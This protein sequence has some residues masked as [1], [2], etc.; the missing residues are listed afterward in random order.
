MTTLAA[1]RWMVETLRGD[2][3]LTALL[4]SNTS[5]YVGKAPQGAARPY[6]L[7][8]L[9]VPRPDVVVVGAM[10]VMTDLGYLVRAIAEARTFSVP[11]AIAARVYTLL[12]GQSGS[13]ADGTV[14]ACV[15]E[16]P[17]EMVEDGPGGIE[18]RHVGGEYRIHT[19]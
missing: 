8:Q 18:L 16:Q 3:T 9:Q 19:Q 13:N 10:R 2:A 4:A 11:A 12:N 6:V 7:I 1:E 14:L 15:H 17:F 5:V